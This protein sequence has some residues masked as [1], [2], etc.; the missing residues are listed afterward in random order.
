M[1][2]YSIY[3]FDSQNETR[4]NEAITSVCNAIIEEN[5][6]EDDLL[7]QNIVDSS[8]VGVQV[9]LE[10]LRSPNINTTIPPYFEIIAPDLNSRLRE[11]FYVPLTGELGFSSTSSSHKELINRFDLFSYLINNGHQFN[12]NI[13]WPHVVID[14]LINPQML[15]LVVSEIKPLMKELL[16]T[17]NEAETISTAAGSIEREAATKVTKFI[18]DINQKKHSITNPSKLGTNTK[19]LIAELKSVDFVKFLERLTG[20]RNLIPDPVERGGGVHIIQ[21]GGYLKAHTDFPFHPNLRLWRRVNVLLYL[22]EYWNEEWGGGLQLWN[23]TDDEYKTSA[24]KKSIS[25]LLNR[26]IVFRTDNH[27]LH[28]HP[29]PLNCPEDVQRVSI[30]LYYYTSDIMPG[31]EIEEATTAFV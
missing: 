27:S 10:T 1:E 5:K 30:A 19:A 22:N 9:G 16:P 6:V 18:D 2:P 13:P 28:G 12:T 25:P 17:P 31:E 7:I 21:R 23:N 8:T 20:I 3:F 15:N 11:N 14:D 4:M 29:E 24:S 26:M